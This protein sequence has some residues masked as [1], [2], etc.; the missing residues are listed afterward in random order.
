MQY[1]KPTDIKLNPENPRI[2]K[3]DKFKKLVE[4]LKSFPEM[5]NVRPVVVNKEHVILGGN[6]RFR[7]MQAAGW[8]KIP[9][10]IV[11]WSEEKQREFVI[12][13][14]VNVGEWDWDVLAN[15]W[16]FEQLG[17]W[18][19]DAP[20]YEEPAIDLKTDDPEF[21]QITFTLHNSQKQIV[22]DAIAKAKNYV[23]GDEP[24]NNSNGNA[25]YY[26]ATNYLEN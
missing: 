7:A 16:D 1:L 20:V 2:I 22:D 14:N 25:L 10:E 4:S 15:E 23:T 17:D 6:M 18:G 24:N 13:D 21:V 5:A 12:K 19:L 9:V 11:D 8:D 26:V 3:D